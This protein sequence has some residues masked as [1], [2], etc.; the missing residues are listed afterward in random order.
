MLVKENVKNLTAIRITTDNLN[1]VFN[2]ISE[3]DLTDCPDDLKIGDYILKDEDNYVYY[4]RQDKFDEI[5]DAVDC[6]IR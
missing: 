5:K 4:C 1:K 6:V 3:T 2:F